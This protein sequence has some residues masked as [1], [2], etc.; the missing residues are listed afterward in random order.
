MKKEV[1]NIC[2]M[3]T[4]RCSIKVDVEDGVVKWIEGSPSDPGMA[5][6]LCAKGSAGIAMLYDYERPQHPLIREGKRGEGKWRK[7]T[8]DEALDYIADKLK[9]IIEKHGARAV[10]LSD[11]GGPFRE[12]H[13]SFLR[14]L[15]SPNYMNHDAT[16]ARNTQHAAISLFGGGRKTFNYDYSQ[17]KHLVLYGRNVLESMRVKNANTIMDLLE[18]GGK[19]TYIDVRAAGTAMKATR[20]WMIRPGTDYALNLGI[21]HTVLKE[22]LY[23]KKF[24][25]KWVSGLKELQDFVE[26]YTPE[27]A[28]EETGIPASEIVE[29]TREVAEASPAVIFHPGWL[30]ARYKDSFYA[31]RTAYILNVLMGSLEAPGGLF[32]QKGPGDAGRKG[33]QRT[34]GHDPQAGRKARGRLRLETQ[35]V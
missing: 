35:A 23:D 22:R 16:C 14:A 26:P 13:R 6:R 29:F 21:I 33:S 17:C 27:W 3:C 2:G 15:G 5:G 18:R 31:S 8:W 32:F 11:R 10:A 20:F 9:T 25:N 7:A 30:T 19:I 34:D 28:A 12:L 24:V 4:V 1:F